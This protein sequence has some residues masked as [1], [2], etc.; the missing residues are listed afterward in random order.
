LIKCVDGKE[1]TVN[2]IA[3]ETSINQS[4]ASERLS[5][6][7]RAGMFTSQKKGKEVY[8]FPDKDNII[9]VLEKILDFLKKCC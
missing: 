9:Q 4:T 8:Y 6:L 7:R 3:E 1:R 2:Q 5:F